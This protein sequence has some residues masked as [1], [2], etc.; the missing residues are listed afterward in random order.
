M[1]KDQSP[2]HAAIA[3]WCKAFEEKWGVKY[4]FTAADAVAVKRFL[5]TGMTGEQL[6]N[7]AKKAWDAPR[8]PAFWNCNKQSATI[9]SFVAA[10][11][12]IIIELSSLAPEEIDY[13]KGF[14]K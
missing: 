14:R 1:S 12:K 2:H 13:S 7:N 5:A 4:I 11:P 3:G 9:H 8:I 10:H 6:V